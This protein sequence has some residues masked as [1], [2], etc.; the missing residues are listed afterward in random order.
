MNKCIDVINP[1]SETEW[2]G[3]IWSWAPY[4]HTELGKAVLAYPFLC[5]HWLPPIDI[6]YSFHCLRERARESRREERVRTRTRLEPNTME[7][8]V[9]PSQ[10]PFIGMVECFVTE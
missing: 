9:L 2:C 8:S 10:S 5:S 1:N 3:A 4:L 6:R 7:S